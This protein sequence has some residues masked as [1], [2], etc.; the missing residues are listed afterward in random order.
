MNHTEASVI[1]KHHAERLAVHH[2]TNA[3]HK[4]TVLLKL[5]QQVREDEIFVNYDI[6]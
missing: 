1:L 3:A 4:A 6:M 5:K 2:S